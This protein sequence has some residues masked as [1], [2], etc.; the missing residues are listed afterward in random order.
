M[1]D[2]ETGDISPY[3]DDWINLKFIVNILSGGFLLFFFPDMFVWNPPPRTEFVRSTT[4]RRKN[5]PGF[6]FNPKGSSDVG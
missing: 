5:P 4:Q 2:L 3:G 6:P 1:D